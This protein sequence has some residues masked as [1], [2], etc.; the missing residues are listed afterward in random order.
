MQS[1]PQQFNRKESLE[2]CDMI[3]PAIVN[4]TLLLHCI[5]LIFMSPH[6]PYKSVCMLNKKLGNV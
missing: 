5:V 3:S 2:M 6:P 1:V 4:T